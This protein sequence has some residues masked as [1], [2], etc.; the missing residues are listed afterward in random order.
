MVALPAHTSHRT[1]MVEYSMLSSFKNAVRKD[2]NCRTISAESY[3]INDGYSLCEIMQTSYLQ[4]LTIINIVSGL[5][6]Y[7]LWN[8]AGSGFISDVIKE[9][10]LTQIDGYRTHNEA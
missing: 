6:S 9:S 4:D 7:G 1:R 8:K 10:Y 2:L 5:H 3:K